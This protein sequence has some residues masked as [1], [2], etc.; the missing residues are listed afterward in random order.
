MSTDDQRAILRIDRQTFLAEVQAEL[1]TAWDVLSAL[2][3][4][5]PNKKNAMLALQRAWGTNQALAG[6]IQEAEAA[7]SASFA[8]ATE[9]REQRDGAMGELNDLIGALDQIW[10]T[11][12]PRVQRAYDEIVEYHNAAFWES[13]PYDMADMLGGQ[14]NFM[15]ANLLHYILTTDIDEVAEDGSDHG[16]TPAQLQAFRSNLLAMLKAFAGRSHPEARDEDL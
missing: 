4:D 10:G 14:W 3:D 2:P 7:L 16:L 12:N 5:H 11:D 13:L 8:A 1:T 15:D 6:L 9:L